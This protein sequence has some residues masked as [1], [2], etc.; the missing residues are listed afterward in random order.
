MTLLNRRD[1]ILKMQA[2]DEKC[3]PSEFD[4]MTHAPISDYLGIEELYMLYVLATDP[5]YADVT[6]QSKYDV[7]DAIMARCNF[8]RYH[9]GTNRIVYRHLY[10]PTFLIK[11]GLD[12][13]GI[14]DNKAELRNQQILKPFVPKVYE[15][16]QCGTVQLCERVYPFTKKEDFIRNGKKIFDTI[17]Y[18]LGGDKF[19]LEDIGT[20]FFMNWGYR[21]NFGPVFL[22]Y[23]YLYVRNADRMKCIAKTK[24]GD[25]LCGGTIDYDEGY[26]ELKCTKCGQRYAA[27]DVG[28]DPSYVF[29]RLK[30]NSVL[31]KDGFMMTTSKKVKFIW[32]DG[33]VTETKNSLD[34]VKTSVA[35]KILSNTKKEN[36]NVKKKTRFVYVEP[37]Q[38]AP[39]KT[40]DE[41]NSMIKKNKEERK[42]VTPILLDAIDSSC[43]ATNH[44]NLLDRLNF[45]INTVDMMQF[46]LN[47]EAYMSI[48]NFLVETRDLAKDLSNL[49]EPK[50]VMKSEFESKDGAYNVK[51]YDKDIFYQKTDP[52]TLEFKHPETEQILN[53]IADMECNDMYYVRAAIDKQ[54]LAT[55]IDEALDNREFMDVR[56]MAVKTLDTINPETK[57]KFAIDISYPVVN[58]YLLADTI[59]SAFKKVLEE[60]KEGE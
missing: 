5:Q 11:I 31:R 59:V 50:V 16:S 46:Q 38:S 34:G 8:S 48:K 33:S 15:V 49:V 47:P 53:N 32:E 7:Y 42:D 3:Q 36:S 30:N 9:I 55:V 26:N 6:K 23:P 28:S 22:D 45:M 44:K 56:Q 14:S 27:K 18:L 12:R 39:E 54:N 58:N 43:V 1:A 60:E 19:I 13:I 25:Q 24:E 41:L 4:L 21:N 40:V 51:F 37:Q 17:Q 2:K 29:K 20:N 35:T 57:G 10:D 52:T